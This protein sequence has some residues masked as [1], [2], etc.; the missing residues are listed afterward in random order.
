MNCREKYAACRREAADQLE[1]ALERG[2]QQVLVRRH[3]PQRGVPGR[4]RCP[5]ALAGPTPTN[6]GGSTT[7][8]M[9]NT[10]IMWNGLLMVEIFQENDATSHGAGC[11]SGFASSRY[12]DAG[13]PV[14]AAR[15]YSAR[16]GNRRFGMVSAHAPAPC[17]VNQF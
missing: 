7:I 9:V 10:T 2:D 14:A 13:A 1:L 5:H 15:M 8:L 3:R 16:A 12:G 17:N 6:A 11:Q 4:G